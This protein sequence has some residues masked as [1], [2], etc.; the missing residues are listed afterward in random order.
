MNQQEVCGEEREREMGRDP[1][2]LADLVFPPIIY[3]MYV[4]IQAIK[5]QQEEEERLMIVMS[6]TP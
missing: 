1:D 5:Q 6:T 2:S 3:T 4:Y